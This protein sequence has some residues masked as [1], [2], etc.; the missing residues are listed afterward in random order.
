MADND[1]N[2]SNS[3][4]SE[5]RNSDQPRD[6]QP[7]ETTV[8][9]TASPASAQSNANLLMILVLF[10][11]LLIGVALAFTLKGKSDKETV[12]KERIK[13]QIA[14]LNGGDDNMLAKGASL[15]AR[16][17]AIVDHATRIRTDYD[18]MRAG[19]T[20]A[21]QQLK[22]L[23]NDQNGNMNTI[24]RLSTSNG[25]LQDENTRLK[26]LASTSNS[27]KQQA[28]MLNERNRELEKQVAMLRNG[29]TTESMKALQ[30]SLSA[31]RMSAS[32]LQNELT[33]LKRQMTGMVDSSKLAQLD[34]FRAQNQKLQ[35]DLA[36]LRAKLD[37]SKLFV[38]SYDQ[39]PLEAQTVF[40]ELKTLEKHS[41]TELADAYAHIG[42]K[43]KAENMQR[44]KFATGSSL[45][46][47]TQQSLLK[48][49]MLA[50]DPTDY[51]LVVGY[52]STSGDAINNETL[53]ANRATS[54]ASLV[55]QLKKSGQDVR[56]VYLGQTSRFSKANHKENQ[57]CEIWRIRK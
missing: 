52:A 9:H 2:T 40:N 5:N 24:T 53:S 26:G 56:A 29:P 35:A 18:S 42:E 51:F 7:Q 19:Y 45:M 16:I 27:Y 14:A 13:N 39:L 57:L 48:N 25:K 28:N 21:K 41:P 17:T 54:V 15:D 10:V 49:K 20:S 34:D 30:D 43:H 3:N 22:V 46:D 6:P 38:K 23:Q 11:I 12:E 55:N 37:F 36:A 31:E 33:A 50:S 32:Q 8:I 47:F 4:R 44:V 1:N